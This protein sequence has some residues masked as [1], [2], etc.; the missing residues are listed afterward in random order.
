[1][2]VVL[3]FV[4]MFG[5]AR[6]VF[7][8]ENVFDHPITEKALPQGLTELSRKFGEFQSMRSETWLLH[9]LRTLRSAFFT[10]T[11]SLSS[12]SMTISG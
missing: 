2:R 9:R 8:T 5:V 3:F 4:V 11:G 1:M 6:S 12:R 7:A 10:E